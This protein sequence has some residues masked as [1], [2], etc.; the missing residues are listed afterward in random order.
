MDTNMSTT[1][2]LINVLAQKFERVGGEKPTTLL[3]WLHSVG[4]A[5]EALLY[6]ILFMPELTVVGNS[7]LL[8]WSISQESEKDR[9]LKLLA[10]GTKE[11]HTLEASFNFIEVGYLFD[12]FGRDTSDEE[13]GLLATLIC[14]AWKA[15]LKAS[16][17]ERIF[18][19]EVLS[20]EDTGSTVGVQFFEVR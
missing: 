10:G 5:S 13:D 16:F 11:L 12:G 20:E 4:K 14:N 1:I 9:F 17:P 8:S 15:W 7:V 2:N 18:C 19:V 3:D 6:S